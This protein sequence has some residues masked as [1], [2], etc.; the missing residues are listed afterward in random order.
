MILSITP[1]PALDETYGLELLDVGG[2]NRVAAPLR[3][4]G[5][6]GINVARVLHSQGVPVLALAPVGGSNGQLFALDLAA[7]GVD[8][9]LLNVAAPMRRSLAV[10][11]HGTGRTTVIN[12]RGDALSHSEWESLRSRIS[13]LLDRGVSVLVA[14]GS[15]P[16]GAD[17]DF[18]PWCVREA[19]RRGIPSIIDTSGPAL[20]AAARAGATVL[21]PNHHELAD[22][23]GEKTLGGGAA[24]LLAAGARHI[25]ASAGEDGL[26]HFSAAGPGHWESARLAAPLVGN[27]TGAGDS[28]VAAIAMG[29]HA[30][31]DHGSVILPRAAAWSASSVLMPTAGQLHPSHLEILTNLI[32]SSATSL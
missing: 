2:S 5:G 25:Y 20:L 11:E 1:N 29:L 18:Y 13:L 3:R 19:T 27:P 21:K 15:L 16:P 14:S 32:H 7:S 28:A 12:E 24:K 9:E 26:F 30:G 8:H 4:A 10:V 6:K 17:E 23:T 31:E 22:V